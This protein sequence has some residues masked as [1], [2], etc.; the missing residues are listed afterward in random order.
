MADGAR[1]GPP[2]KLKRAAAALYTAPPDQK[3]LALWGLKPSDF[4]GADEAIDVWP[5]NEA[6]VL[7]FADIGAG[8]WNVGTG[9]PLGIRP[10]AMRE[11]RFARG[12]TGPQWREMF[13]DIRL[14]EGEALA[15]LKRQSKDK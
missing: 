1:A 11:I 14:M 7:F 8:C 4:G 9:G 15:T 12:I 2:G 5:D 13:D 10:E 6:A 3:E